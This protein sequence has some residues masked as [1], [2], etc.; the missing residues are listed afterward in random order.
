MKKIK[1]GGVGGGLEEG[2][3]I[4]LVVFLFSFVKLVFRCF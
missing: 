1:V 2:S 3:R 4:E